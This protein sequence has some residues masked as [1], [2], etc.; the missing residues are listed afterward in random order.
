MEK[1]ELIVWLS[2]GSFVI[3]GLLIFI[4]ISCAIRAKNNTCEE[5][6]AFI[7]MYNSKIAQ[8]Y[9]EAEKDKESAK[10]PVSGKESFS[11]FN[12]LM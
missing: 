1:L 2:Y 3:L 11:L 4:I 6:Q 8:G 9:A 10:K 5:E 7:R 12:M